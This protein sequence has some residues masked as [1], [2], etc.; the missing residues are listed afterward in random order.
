M[1]FR[2]V[3][4]QHFGPLGSAGESSQLES[5]IEAFLAGDGQPDRATDQLLNA[6]HLLRPAA[7]SPPNEADRQQL[8]A[9]LHR[10]LSD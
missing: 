2:S 4:E 7:T 8:R 5:E 6:W 10:R 9:I 1:L 3:V